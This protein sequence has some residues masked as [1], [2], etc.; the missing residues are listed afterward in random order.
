M[1]KDL[2]DRNEELEMS[3]LVR[4]PHTPHENTMKRK[5]CH[6]PESPP[7]SLKSKVK[8]KNTELQFQACT[9]EPQ[10][11]DEA[12]SENAEDDIIS[13]SD[14]WCSFDRQYKVIGIQTNENNLPLSVTYRYQ[15]LAN[16]ILVIQMKMNLTM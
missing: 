15:S 13:L 1:N 11:T 6:L 5:G 14:I 2:K 8:K 16:L 12:E 3:I 4:N 9:P 10:N 7:N